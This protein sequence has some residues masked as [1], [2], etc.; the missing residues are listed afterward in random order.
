LP[1]WLPEL[2]IP[3]LQVGD[4]STDLLLERHPH[5]VGVTVLQREGR[6]RVS[7]VK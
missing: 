1:E 7:V 4:A 2:R 3:N 5:D 6:L